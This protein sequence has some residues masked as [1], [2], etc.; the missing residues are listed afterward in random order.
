MFPKIQRE[1]PIVL[2]IMIRGANEMRIA[3]YIAND[4]Y[5]KYDIFSLE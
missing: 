3:V 2:G 5:P 4:N 1:Y